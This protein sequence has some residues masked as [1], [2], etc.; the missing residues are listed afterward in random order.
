MCPSFS[1]LLCEMSR[2]RR[3]DGFESSLTSSFCRR[4]VGES[5]RPMEEEKK[6]KREAV[7]RRKRKN[8]FERRKK[9]DRLE[10]RH[11]EKRYIFLVRDESEY[12]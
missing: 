8:D 11:T 6:K 4:V 5:R 2:T 9:G 7:Q 10:E 3:R 1:S 12:D